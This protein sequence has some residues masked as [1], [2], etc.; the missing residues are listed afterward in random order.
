MGY[1]TL[2]ARRYLRSK[3]QLRF[4]NVIMLISVI[5]ITV[6][7]GALVVVLS[8]FNGFNSVVTGVLV[9][10]DPHIRIEPAAGRSIVL[11]DSVGRLVAREGSAVAASPF[12]AGKALLTTSRAQRVVYVRGVVDSS[13]GAV[14][15]VRDRI[16]LGSFNTAGGGGTGLV[17]GIALADRLGATVGTEVT[18]VSPVGL[19]A[20]LV[21]FGRPRTQRLV[22]RGIYDSNNR[23]YDAQYAYLDLGMAQSLFRSGAG[24]S[25]LE[26][27]VR[28]FGGADRVR[29]RLAALLGPD[30]AV[31][32][33]YDLHADLYSIMQ[34]ERWAAYVILCLIVS[35]ATFNVLGSLTMGVIEKRRDIGILKA[36]GATRSSIRRVFMF[37]GILVGSLGTVAGIL[38]GLLVCHLQTEF[39]LFRLDPTVYIIPAIPVDVRWTDFLA[40]GLAS[41]LLSSLASFYPASRAARLLPVEAIRWE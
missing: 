31:M 20:M 35:V 11:D 6:G 33:W 41:M 15:G 19:D 30:Y 3:R 37:E 32:S 40:V 14:S 5:G 21:Q 13:V 2:I 18:L 29:E 38:A 28:D 27:R 10:F 8:V 34:I 7:V 16:V 22:V 17:L 24:V 1:E 39:H 12:L 4:I 25:G 26:L 9:G 36:M 23:E